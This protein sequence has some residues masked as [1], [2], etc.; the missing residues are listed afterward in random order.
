MELCSNN[1]AHVTLKHLS[2][3]TSQCVQ[4]KKDNY[5]ALAQAWTSTCQ[6]PKLYSGH[7]LPFSFW[8]PPHSLMAIQ[9]QV[10][11]KAV[12]IFRATW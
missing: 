4:E 2:V 7:S 5:Q 8:D 11:G 10:L 3:F 6:T 1:Q 12:N 9:Q